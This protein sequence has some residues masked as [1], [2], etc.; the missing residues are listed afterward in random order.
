[1]HAR[2]QVC[3]VDVEAGAWARLPGR[4]PGTPAASLVHRLSGLLPPEIRVQQ[5]AEVPASFDARFSALARR[6]AYRICDDPA[7]ADPLRREVLLHRRSL[8]AAAMDSAA[9]PLV[10]EHDFAA[11]CKQ[12]EGATTIRRILSLRCLRDA[13]GLVV[14]DIQADAFC[15]HMVRSIVGTLVAVGEGRREL[16]WPRPSG[17]R[18]SPW[19]RPVASR[20]SR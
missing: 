12:R 19:S 20:S 10:G 2:G 8:D 4:S 9:A 15:H 1:M 16:A 7:T 13:E 5:A 3:H 14:V 17:T 6:Y 11:F 18:Q